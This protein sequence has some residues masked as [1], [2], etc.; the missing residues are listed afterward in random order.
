[1]CS[2]HKKKD[3]EMSSASQKKRFLSPVVAIVAM[4]LIA[5]GLALGAVYVLKVT[6]EHVVSV[7][8]LALAAVLVLAGVAVFFAAFPKGCRTCRKRFTDARTDFSPAEY[9]RVAA[10]VRGNAPAALRA[11]A[12]LPNARDHSAGLIVSYCESCRRVGEIRV[13]E[14]RN[15]GQFDEL[16][17]GTPYESLSPE[18]LVAALDLVKI[19]KAT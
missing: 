19:R 14:E 2:D 8:G 7:K 11:L 15:N 12:D 16:V 6:N 18:M 1:M 5:I 9:D 3:R 4:V 13:I 17:K 10:A